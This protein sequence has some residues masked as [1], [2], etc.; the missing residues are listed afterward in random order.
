MD[1]ALTDPATVPATINNPAVQIRKNF[2]ETAFFF[3]S[4]TTDEK[5][6]ISF[7]FTIPEALTQWKLM[8][9]AHD[10][11]LASAY[12]ERTVIT[13]KPLMV[14]P[15]APR[16]VREGDRIE[17]ITKVAG[18]LTEMAKRKLSPRKK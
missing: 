15:N 13:Q 8:I 10:K 7:S 1:T 18:K 14:Q 12:S 9:L 16:F 5:G 11:Q 6:N 17:L 3:P 2:N 4:L